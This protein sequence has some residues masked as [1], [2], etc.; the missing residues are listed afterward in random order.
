MANISVDELQSR[1]AALTDQDPA[2][3]NISS[4]EYALRLRFLNMAQQEWAELTDWQVLYKEYNTLTSTSSGNAS[5]A[6]PAD[7]RKLASYPVI[8]YDGSETSE[9]P[10]IRPQE[11]GRYTD[12][13]KRIYVLGNPSDSYTMVVDGTDLASGASIKIPYYSSPV[14]LASPT[15]L[16]ACPNPE[17][18]VQRAVSYWWQAREDTRFI[19]AK[20]EADMILRNMLE[21]ETVFG[22]AANYD[23][24]RSVEERSGF[25]WG[26]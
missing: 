23:K 20:Q 4:D 11:S 22:D 17:F 7:F 25:R 14:S 18:L 24:V 6:L 1:I 3:S 10:E 26:E 5:I 9:F 16:S 8:T 13:D 15:N 2:T 12:T 19:T 21:Y